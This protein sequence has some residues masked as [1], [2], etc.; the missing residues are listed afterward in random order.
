MIATGFLNKKNKKILNIRKFNS[1]DLILENECM[2]L[3]GITGNAKHRFDIRI[4]KLIDVRLL[5]LP[6]IQTTSRQRK[7]FNIRHLREN[8]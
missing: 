5:R 6:D 2:I 4:T 3:A 7:R 1:R 8:D